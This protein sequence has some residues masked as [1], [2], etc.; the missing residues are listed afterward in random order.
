MSV[1]Y[2]R[3]P[4]APG[5]AEEPRSTD[6]VLG[7]L[8]ARADG[9]TAIE[10]WREDAIRFVTHG[11]S[12]APAVGPVAWWAASL[13][14]AAP[15]HARGASDREAPAPGGHVCVATPVHCVA[16]MSSVGLP[17]GGILRLEAD[18]AGEFA[19]DFN[20]V[21]HG[22]GRRLVVPAEVHGDVASV[23]GEGEGD[24]PPDPPAAPG[25]QGRPAGQGS[26]GGVTILVWDG[27]RAR[28]HG[29]VL[30]CGGGGFRPCFPGSATSS[31][32]TAR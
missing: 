10:D 7:R 5:D 11:K 31:T 29:V 16:G 26:G 24:R 21:F 3:F 19:A 25:D 30:S 27:G 8:L 20:R 14:A 12:A 22:G 18:E 4:V 1:V 32:C 23:G 9:P 13:D 2:V 28:G 6:R 15:A 17:P